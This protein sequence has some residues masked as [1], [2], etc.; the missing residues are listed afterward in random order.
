LDV[1]YRRRTILNRVSVELPE[2]TSL[3]ITGRSGSGKSTLISAILSLTSP[4]H[5]SILIKG[6]DVT[7]MRRGERRE[8][9]NDNISVVFQHGELIDALEPIENVAIPLLLGE[10]SKADAFDQAAQLLDQLGVRATGLP[11]RVLSGGEKQRVAVARALITR[12][13]IIIADE[14]TGSLDS[15]FRDLVEDLILSIPQRWG[16]SL[17]FVTHD[18]NL[19][20]RADIHRRLVPHGDHGASLEDTR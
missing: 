13:S 15:E 14:P 19:A 1:S 6:Q 5:G 8:H 10:E 17:L 18:L 3:A 4:S 11:T 12:P 2:T 20:Q 16:A 7:R 9:I